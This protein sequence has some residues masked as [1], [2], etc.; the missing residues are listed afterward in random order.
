MSIIA[1]TL[2]TRTSLFSR[3]RLFSPASSH[4]PL[5]HN[6]VT[7]SQHHPTLVVPKREGERASTTTSRTVFSYRTRTTKA[8]WLERPFPLYPI[9]STV[10]RALRREREGAFKVTSVQRP[11]VVFWAEKKAV[12]VH[13]SVVVT[14]VIWYSHVKRLLLQQCV[15]K[16][17]FR[18]V[19]VGRCGRVSGVCG[20]FRQWQHK[21]RVSRGQHAQAAT[22]AARPAAQD[23]HRR[24]RLQ[25]TGARADIQMLPGKTKL[26][27]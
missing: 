18:K 24:F 17:G 27:L 21:I 22:T 3:F 20:L 6:C 13:A 2:V 16:H 4:H 19:V 7:S 15:F 5:F 10:E 9:P 26:L 1:S 14:R 12:S 23:L 8:V 11:L 25:G